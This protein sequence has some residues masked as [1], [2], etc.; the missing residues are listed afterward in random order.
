MTRMVG[1]ILVSYLMSALPGM[2]VKSLDST[3]TQ[4]GATHIPTYAINWLNALIS[5]VIYVVCNPTYRA[6]ARRQ[7]AC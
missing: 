4:Y 6:A 7:F 5:P 1:V 2:L 3:G